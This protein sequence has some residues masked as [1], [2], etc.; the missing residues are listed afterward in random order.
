MIFD[1]NVLVQAISSSAGPSANCL[2]LVES[3]QIEV[4]LIRACLREFRDVMNCPSV[5]KQIL[6]LT[7]ED[8]NVF[9]DRLLFRGTLV[10]KVPH[11]F[12]YPRAVQDEPH[13]DLAAAADADFLVTRDL[14]L[15]SLAIDHSII[16]KEFRQRFPR[17]HVVNPLGF[18]EAIQSK[19]K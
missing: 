12:D 13:V 11:V 9:I 8:I 15:L 2:R 19:N 14:D 4:F 3:N 16:A 17:L 7:D 18:M 6:D 10:R 1:C 5:R